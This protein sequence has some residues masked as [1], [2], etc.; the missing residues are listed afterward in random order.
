M[1]IS[2]LIKNNIK[3]LTALSKNFPTIQSV[4]TEIINLKA[5]LDLPKG[6]EH[7]VSDI[8]GEHEAFIHILNSASGVIHEK[9][10]I[11]FGKTQ[12]LEERKKLATL[13]YYP[14]QK[15]QLIKDEVENIDEW[16]KKV[17]VELIEICRLVSSKYTRSKVRKALPKDF[18]YILDELL[19]AGHDGKNKDE[20]YNEIIKAIIEIDRADAFIVALADVIKRLA[21]DRLHIVGDIFDRGERPDII[22]DTLMNHHSVDIQ[23]GNHDI[24]W[25]GAA[26]GS[27]TCISNVLNICL[28]FS[29]LDLLE[30]GYGIS[31][32]PLMTFAETT[33]TEGDQFKPKQYGEYLGDY[34]KLLLAKMRKAITVILFKTEGTIIKRN[35]LFEMQPRLLLDKINYQDKT[36]TI[37][38]NVYPIKDVNFPTINPDDPYALTD[39]E[40]LVIA[41]LK[42]AFM[43]SEKLQKH[44]AFLYSKGSIYKCFNSNLL[45]HGCVPMNDDGSFTELCFDSKKMSGKEYLDY[46]D[47]MARDAFFLPE[48]SEE[49]QN[50]K[51]FIW[52]LWC[53]KHSPLFGRHAMTTFERCEIADEEVWKEKKDPYYTFTKD[54]EYCRKIL[55]EFGLDPFSSHIING[56]VPVK[57][58]DG[59][60]PLKANGK[61]INIDGGF[62]KHYQKTTGIAGYTLTYNSYCLRLISH[63]PFKTAQYAIENNYDIVSTSNVFETVEKRKTVGDTDTGNELRTQ[64]DD[65][66]LLLKAYRLGIINESQQK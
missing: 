31:L 41:E 50:G 26:A 7:F 52:Y 66:M 8:H 23:W 10:D 21:V 60:S 2:E 33:Y 4:S 53:G 28:R 65:L 34:D 11:L 12:S 47:K 48:T 29:A 6:T 35:P 32:R 57:I 36:V 24:L 27:E 15:L 30:I 3:Y 19:H 38:D 37:D 39:E 16:Y 17:L 25:M 14:S 1:E 56:H 59:E 44:I 46:C 58:K 55:A 22:M 42:R 43:Q 9:I 61:L 13:I 54:A 63:E 20:Y 64:I 18:A 62:C 51:D 40:K 5:I 49:K 45:Y